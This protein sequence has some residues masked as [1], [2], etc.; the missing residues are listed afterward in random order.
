MGQSKGRTRYHRHGWP[1]PGDV[2]PAKTRHYTRDYLWFMNLQE[3]NRLVHLALDAFLG[4]V[5][6]NWKRVNFRPAEVDGRH[7][8]YYLRR[9]SR[10]DRVAIDSAMDMLR[11]SAIAAGIPSPLSFSVLVDCPPPITKSD[12]LLFLEPIEPLAIR[13]EGLRVELRMLENAKDAS[14]SHPR[15][16]LQSVDMD[17]L[18]DLACSLSSN[19]WGFT[20]ADGGLEGCWAEPQLKEGLK[21]FVEDNIESCWHSVVAMSRSALPAARRLAFSVAGA[22]GPA[23]ANLLQGGEGD[24]DPAVRSI[25]HEGLAELKRKWAR[26]SAGF[27]PRPILRIRDREGAPILHSK[28][29][30][31]AEAVPNTECSDFLDHCRLQ[32]LQAIHGF[33]SPSL[34]SCSLELLGDERVKVWFLLTEDC[35]WSREG[36]VEAFDDFITEGHFGE[37]IEIV[38]DDEVII[39]EACSPRLP[40]KMVFLRDEARV[41]AVEDQVVQS[42]AA[43]LDDVC[44]LSTRTSM[45]AEAWAALQRAWASAEGDEDLI[46]AAAMEADHFWPTVHD[47]SLSELPAC[48]R[49]AY[50]VASRSG[51]HADL[52]LLRGLVDPDPDCRNLALELQQVRLR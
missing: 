48:R 49:Q 37:D 42:A 1:D 25:S 11:D 5:S 30:G 13:E 12:R 21:R 44:E 7:F 14:S 51:P 52:L 43:Q 40:G 27:R 22:A 33:Q 50:R 36:L 16:G 29:A 47:L 38:A 24:E 28:A 35:R 23:A 10:R 45:T 4:R 41:A 31:D 17:R 2:A 34:H 39:S 19:R 9:P 32:L 26:E 46:R 6:S 20:T 18:L 8:Y 3:E 15:R